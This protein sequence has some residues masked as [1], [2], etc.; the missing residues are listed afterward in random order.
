MKKTNL[1]CKKN[2]SKESAYAHFY[3]KPA[4]V[5]FCGADKGDVVEVIV[6]E[7]KEG[8]ESDY[9]GWW[10]NEK[11]KFEMVYASKVQSDICFT[12]GA[13]AEEEKGEGKQMNVFIEEVL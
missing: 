2:E 13:Q 7:L 1:F 6:R 8:E 12:Y 3:S 9:W 5:R 4:L 10:N 11:E